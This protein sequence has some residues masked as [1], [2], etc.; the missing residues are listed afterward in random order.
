M[1]TTENTLTLSPA[2]LARLHKAASRCGMKIEAYAEKLL[3]IT[4]AVET[5]PDA[6]DKPY[7]VM[8]F[9][10]VAPSGRSAAEID[11]EINALRDE[12]DS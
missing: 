2:I 7:S 1:P 6:D 11:A 4:L 3:E 10:G 12:W 8:D 9:Y 5:Q